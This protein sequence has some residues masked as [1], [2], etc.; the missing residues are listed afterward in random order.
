MKFDRPQK[1]AVF[2][3]GD[4]KISVHVVGEPSVVAWT[5]RGSFCGIAAQPIIDAGRCAHLRDV[6][7]TRRFVAPNF[8][9]VR[10]HGARCRCAGHEDNRCAST[11]M[12][13]DAGK[14]RDH[15]RR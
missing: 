14:G 12:V 7:L 8:R 2:L 1:E 9:E 5:K 10:A 15:D 11:K 13:A 6:G 4:E 3:D